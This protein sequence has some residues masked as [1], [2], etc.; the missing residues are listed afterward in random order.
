MTEIVLAYVGAILIA[1]EFVRK[2]TNL[3]ALMGMLVGWPVSSFFGEKGF[4]N[5]SE[6]YKAHKLNVIFRMIF[7]LVLCLITLPLTVAF[8]VIWFIIL[9]L[10]SL[11][12]WVNGLYFEGKKRYRPFYIFII[13]LV[14]SA[15]KI[16]EYK[17]YADIDEEKVMQH[18]EKTELPILPIIGVILITIAFIMHIV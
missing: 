16:T 5:W 15:H 2:F 13:G 10:N 9:V 12:N 11:H 3:Q 6:I 8:Y 4:E 14:L 18:I 7:S 1:M 17:K